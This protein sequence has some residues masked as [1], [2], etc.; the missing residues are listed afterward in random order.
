MILMYVDS[1]EREEAVRSAA[2]SIGE[3]VSS[4][5]PGELS[6]KLSEIIKKNTVSGGLTPELQR[7]LPFQI[8]PPVEEAVPPMYQMPEILIF[9]SIEE[10]GIRTFLS[11]FRASGE[12]PVALKAAVTPFN[13][14]W[15]LYALIGELNREREALKG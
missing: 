15:T 8:T 11:A 2:A 9:V 12:K 5:G 7:P 10:E 1:K 14:N 4:I 6:L 3:R 13:I